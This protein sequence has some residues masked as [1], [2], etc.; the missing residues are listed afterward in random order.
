MVRLQR[1][2]IIL[3]RRR[4]ISDRIF[5][6]IS[7]HIERRVEPMRDET[8][9]VVARF[10]TLRSRRRIICRTY[11]FIVIHASEQQIAHRKRTAR[12]RRF[13]QRIVHIRRNLLVQIR[14]ARIDRR[15]ENVETDDE[16][17]TDSNEHHNNGKAKQL[18]LRFLLSRKRQRQQ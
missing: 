8:A 16:N 5:V 17:Q 1:N 7:P 13:K 2:D 14:R 11:R 10:D 6:I 18:L 9:Q 4:I 12:R 3:R 15:I